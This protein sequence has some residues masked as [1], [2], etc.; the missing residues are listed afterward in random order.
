MEV[1]RSPLLELFCDNVERAVSIY[2]LSGPRVGVCSIVFL[3]RSA[4]TTQLG[5]STVFTIKRSTT[6]VFERKVVSVFLDA[7]RLS[8]S[9]V[10]AILEYWQ[11]MSKIK[12]EIP[13]TY[14]YLCG[15]FIYANVDEHT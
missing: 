6:L 8:D 9:N 15:W 13:L 10:F 14:Q 3:S 7:F 5:G 12:S 4:V 2:K 11:L 1:N